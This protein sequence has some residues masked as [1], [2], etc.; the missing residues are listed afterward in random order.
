MKRR[1][2]GLALLA[3]WPGW[4]PAPAGAQARSPRVAWV[5]A[6]GAGAG[7]PLLLA[8]RQ[9]LQAQGWG[10]DRLVLDPWWLDGGADRLKTV[11]P[12]LQASRPDIVVA[13]SGLLVRPLVDAGVSVPLVFVHSADV[14]QARLVDSWARPGVNRTGVSL[15]SLELLP[16]RLELLQ[17]LLPRA[18]R[19]ALVGWP[20]H[21]GET[22]ELQAA[23]DAADRLGLAHQYHGVTTPTELAAAFDAI[24]TWRADAVLV[25]AGAVA[26]SHAERFATFAARQRIPAVSA[27][28]PFA[29]AGNLMSYGPV[30]HDSYAR[31][32]SFVDRLLQGARAAELPV[33]QP[34]RFELVI[35]QQAARALGLTVPRELLLRAD[36]LIG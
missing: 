14:V 35:N 23:R 15:F 26:S 9:G 22:L 8:F 6:L 3:G 7:A 29:E 5:S 4:A 30:L 10:D 31:L 25:F 36:R 17:R 16:K 11:W 27:W 2:L 13:A 12:E 1:E 24:A 33:E 34:T 21:G 32:A 18:R 20:P 28:A 19:V